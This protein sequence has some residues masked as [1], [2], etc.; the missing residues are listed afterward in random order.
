MNGEDTFSNARVIAKIINEEINT[1]EEY[2]AICTKYYVSCYEVTGAKV[3]KS[4]EQIDLEVS[5]IETAEHLE[6]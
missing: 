5:Y 1:F 6:Q 3:Y 2:E 4:Q